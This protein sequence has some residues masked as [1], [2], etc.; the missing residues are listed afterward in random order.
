MTSRVYIR[1]RESSAPWHF[2]VCRNVVKSG[3]LRWAFDELKH[4]SRPRA[5]DVESTVTRPKRD[6]LCVNCLNLEDCAR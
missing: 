1:H 6:A 2:F 5:E 3:A 4:R